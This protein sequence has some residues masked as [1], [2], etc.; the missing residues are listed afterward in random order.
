MCAHTCVPCSERQNPYPNPKPNLNP[1][2]ALERLAPSVVEGASACELG[3]GCG[4]PGLVL[5]A[6]GAR[7]VLTDLAANLPLLEE[8]RRSNAHA[9][10]EEVP[11]TCRP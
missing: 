4:L 9:W 3:A 2:Q 11:P 10:A 7:V 5:A 6:R 8:N 1:N